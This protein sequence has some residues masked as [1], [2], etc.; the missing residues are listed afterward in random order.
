MAFVGE[1]E[2]AI[3]ASQLRASEAST[4]AERSAVALALA[5]PMLAAVRPSIAAS[6]PSK[7]RKR[8]S[9]SLASPVLSGGLTSVDFADL[10]LIE[11][12]GSGAN[13]GEP[14]TSSYV[15][16]AFAISQ[17]V[18]LNLPFFIRCLAH[19]LLRRHGGLQ[20]FEARQ[21][22]QCGCH[23]PIFAR[24]CAVVAVR[25]PSRYRHLRR[26]HYRASHSHAFGVGSRRRSARH[27]EQ[28]LSRCE[29]ALL[30][31]GSTNRAHLTPVRPF[32]VARPVLSCPR[33][34]TGCCS[35]PPR[36]P[37]RCP[38]STTR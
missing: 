6:G 38:I 11:K 2:A 34:R 37:A 1:R 12:A 5:S 22:C 24:G 18:C 32:P 25:P 19:D 26:L 15:F 7:L 30:Y 3:V 21:G 9:S 4:P 35:P 28:L 33:G 17:N 23:Q 13:A 31:E 20:D 16:R 27:V 36:S 8:A 10:Q 29:L 14:P